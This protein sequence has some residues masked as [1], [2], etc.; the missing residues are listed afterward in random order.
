LDL[1]RP[2]TDRTD[3]RVAAVLHYLDDTHRRA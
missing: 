1:V 2:I 3:R